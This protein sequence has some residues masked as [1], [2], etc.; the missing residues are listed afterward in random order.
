MQLCSRCGIK[1]MIE[2]KENGRMK[3]MA[4]AIRDLYRKFP[5][6]HDW[7]FV[8]SFNPYVFIFVSSPMF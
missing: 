3:E 8:A 5:N 1:L 2:V 7:A 4:A 6:A